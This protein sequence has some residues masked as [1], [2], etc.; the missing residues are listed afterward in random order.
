MSLISKHWKW[1]MYQRNIL[2]DKSRMIAVVK[3]RQIGLTELA[4]VLAV[5]IALTKT[6]NDVWLLG[7]N[8]E[9]SKEIL[10]RAKAWYE[11]LILVHP[12]LPS[13]RSISTEQII[14]SNNSR[15]TALPCSAKSIRGKSGTLILDEFAH[16]QS[17]EEIWTAIAP[18]IS[19]NKSLR[20]LMFS[21]PFGERGV[22][23]RAVTGKLD[24][25]KLKWSI[26]N[27]NVHH[28]IVD[29]HSEDVLDLRA[30]FTEEQWAQEFLC[31]FLSQI[32]KYFPASLIA[33]S[34]EVELG[35]LEERV[36]CSRVLGIDLA[37]KKDQSVTIQCD[38][39]GED[40]YRIHNPKILS[41]KL[42]PKTYAEQ[43][44]I[45]KEHISNSNYDKVIVDATGPGAGL[46]SFLRAEFGSLI[47]EHNATLQWKGRY[48]PALKV[49][50]ESDNIELE[51][52]QDIVNAFNAVKETRSSSNNIIY[53]MARDEIGHADLFSA[54]LM[55]Y[56]VVK[57]FPTDKQALPILIRT[58]NKER[59]VNRNARY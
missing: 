4:S 34:Y 9:G 41:T 29:G 40:G 43:F 37:S 30:S 49:D 18:V 59:K 50:M 16:V 20:L 52:N 1:R 46:A 45:L 12:D 5:K 19:S 14:F 28:A 35:A 17:D 26:H 22:F 2:L 32:G 54:A 27:I 23:W 51:H 3:A 6:K 21:T 42:H 55:A 57:R 44:E 15:I 13:I 31:S 7:V 25:E 56:S 36:V 38:W 58:T 8:H 10:W 39:D 24:G 48:I 33:Q 11:A 47:I 53:S